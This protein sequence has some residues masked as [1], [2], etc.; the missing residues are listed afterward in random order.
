MLD[1]AFTIADL[2]YYLLILT[3]ISC[4]IF[5]SPFFGMTNTPAR[6]KVGI[7]FF[8]SVM[9]YYTL[10]KDYPIYIGIFGYAIVVLKEAATGMVIGIGAQICISIASFAGRLI[11]MEVGLSMVN[12]MD[13]TTKENATITGVFYKNIIMII[14]IITGMYQYLLKAIAESF[15]LIPINGAVFRYESMVENIV[16]FTRD[17]T[18]IGFRI[19]LPVLAAIIILNTVLGVLAKV[20]PQLNMFA[21]GI[22]LKIIIGLIVVYLSTTLLVQNTSIIFEEMK[23]MVVLFVKSLM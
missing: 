6:V 5:V 16:I 17:F 4:F 11:D 18:I 13:P 2:E 10:P 20:A 1:Y 23:R 3:R 14:L 7:S 12:Q 21:V 22:Q 15:E 9:L 19:C 8:V